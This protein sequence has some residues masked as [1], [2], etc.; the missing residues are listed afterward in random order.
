MGLSTT[1]RGTDQ[2]TDTYLP[3]TD[4]NIKSVVEFGL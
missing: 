2:E 1:Q 4:E 3:N